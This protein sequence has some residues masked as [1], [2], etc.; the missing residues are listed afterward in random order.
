MIRLLGCRQRDELTKYFL[1][2]MMTYNFS[3]GSFFSD[4]IETDGPAPLPPNLNVSF[5]MV[6]VNASSP[7]LYRVV[8]VN[9]SY[10]YQ[11]DLPKLYK[12]R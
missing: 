1:V 9:K 12:R 2:I 11:S 3:G 5:G 10:T 4:D 8:V 6:G 7:L